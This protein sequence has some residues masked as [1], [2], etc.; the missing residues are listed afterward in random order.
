MPLIIVESPTKARTFNRILKGPAQPKPTGK[1]S[2]AKAA[3]APKPKPGPNDYY[4]FAT[5][6][7]IRDLPGDKMSIDFEHNFKPEYKV[8]EKKQ[9]DITQM[10]ELRSED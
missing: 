6:G 2:R 5:L 1:G 4:V 9:K 8:M 3:A 10:Q 7:H